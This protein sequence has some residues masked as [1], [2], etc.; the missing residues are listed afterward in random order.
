VKGVSSRPV[1]RLTERNLVETEATIQER[2]WL[3]L[4]RLYLGVIFTVAAFGKLT[5]RTDF[6]DLLGSFSTNVALKT[7]YGWYAGFVRHVVLPNVHLFATLVIAGESFVAVSML[8]GLLTRAGAIVAIG[9]LANYACGKGFAPWSPASNDVADI[10][11]ALV[12]LF[13]S[14]G[15]VGGIDKS[16]HERFPKVPLW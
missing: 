8:F 4:P 16:L 10:V 12:V 15:R 3:L 13:G 9:L 6:A 7:G 14:A 1:D 11:I 2:R 5:E